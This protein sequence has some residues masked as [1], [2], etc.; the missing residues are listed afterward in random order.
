MRSIQANGSRTSLDETD[1]AIIRHLQEDGRMSY[2]DLGPLIGLSPAAARQ[3]VLHLVDSGVMQ[4]VAVTDPTRLGFDIQAMV[5]FRVTGDLDGVA[6]R[7]REM[8]EV[9]YLVITTGRFDLLAEI[10]A[11]SSE[12]FLA[13]LNGIRSLE[14]VQSSEVFTYLRLEK[15]SYDWGVR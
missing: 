3:R 12:D 8:A 13:T 2:A 15:Q 1:K 5:G 14:G 6:R 4:I 11:T 10:V 9:D 7:V